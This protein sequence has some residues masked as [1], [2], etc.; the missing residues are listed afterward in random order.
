[1]ISGRRCSALF[2]VS[3][4]ILTAGCFG[5]REAL[6]GT[7]G[8][9][10]WKRFAGDS[11]VVLAAGD[12]A[13]C[14][15][16]G[17][18]RTAAMLDTLAG[19]VLA[20]GDQVY[21]AG[22]AEQFR[23][24]YGP[25]WGRHKARTYPAPGNHEYRS[26]NAAPYFAYFGDAAGPAGRGYYSFNLGAWHVISLNSNVAMDEE[27][28]QQ[29]WLRADLAANPRRC[30]LAFWHHPRFSSGPHGPTPD[31]APLWRTLAQAGVDVV[32]QGH[33]HGYERFVPMTADGTPDATRGIRS[34]V[35]GGGGASLYP[36]VHT[37]AGSQSR[38]NLGWAIGRFTLRDESYEWELILAWDGTSVDRGGEVCH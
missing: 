6:F 36:F 27:S 1:M 9:G 4:A 32:L 16:V 14:D 26:P 17:D 34:F 30:T 7:E 31:V 28:A 2:A 18:E 25:S 15:G 37:A 29:R 21:P 33:D 22:T 12:I 38:Y 23:D 5:Q 3:L 11:V 8:A 24:C 10:G 20:L 19:T 13:L 35:I